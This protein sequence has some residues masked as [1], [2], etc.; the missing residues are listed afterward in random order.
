[1][2]GGHMNE[3][4]HGHDTASMTNTWSGGVLAGG[5]V[6]VVHRYVQ[7]LIMVHIVVRQYI[8]YL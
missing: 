4:D 5:N 1:M 7:Y 3:S 6:E 8:Q 2:C